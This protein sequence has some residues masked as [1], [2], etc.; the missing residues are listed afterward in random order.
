MGLL[1]VGPQVRRAQ[2][3]RHE[4]ELEKVKRDEITRLG[5]KSQDMSHL[6]FKMGP[7]DRQKRPPSPAAV[8]RVC[9][10]AQPGGSSHA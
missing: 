7:Q 4:R 2:E 6:G 3:S 10:G 9:C 1:A 8:E 5:F